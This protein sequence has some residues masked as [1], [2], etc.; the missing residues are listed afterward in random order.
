VHSFGHKSLEL[1]GQFNP[2]R[3]FVRN[4]RKEK[5]CHSQRPKNGGGGG[6]ATR[7]QCNGKIETSKKMK[8]IKNKK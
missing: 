5:I 1:E 7:Q 2:S 8:I 3:K 4:S 6:D